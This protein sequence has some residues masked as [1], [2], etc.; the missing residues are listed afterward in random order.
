MDF[1]T[2]QAKVNLK[3]D[4]TYKHI[5]VQFRAILGTEMRMPPSGSRSAM[6]L[7][8]VTARAAPQS[9]SLGLQWRPRCEI[10]K[11]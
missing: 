1:K 8:P 9:Q 10:I 7:F 6:C 2:V 4:D 5:L 3:Y 11:G